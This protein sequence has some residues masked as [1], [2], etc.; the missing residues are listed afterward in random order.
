MKEMPRLQITVTKHLPK[1]G[2]VAGAGVAGVEAVLMEEATL[3]QQQVK[4]LLVEGVSSVKTHH[5][6][7]TFVQAGACKFYICK[8][9]VCYISIFILE[10]IAYR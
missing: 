4:L 9:V 8:Y 3:F 2:G 1:A 6:L 5:T 10:L 7:L